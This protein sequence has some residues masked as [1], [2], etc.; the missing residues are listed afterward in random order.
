MAFNQSTD[1][2][3]IEVNDTITIPSDSP[4]A[5]FEQATY[6]Y[7]SKMKKAAYEAEK[8]MLQVE[9]LKVQQWVE[10]T[11]QKVVILLKGA[12]QPVKV[13]RSNGLPNT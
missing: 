1:T 5:R 8:A 7:K 13:E 12:T 11:G 10:E 3:K 9:L 4:Q 6:P 2:S